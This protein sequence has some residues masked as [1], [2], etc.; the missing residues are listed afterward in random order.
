MR[1]TLLLMATVAV[2]FTF[3]ACS[4]CGGTAG[5]CD[6]GWDF[7]DECDMIE[8]RDRMCAS[9]PCGAGPCGPAPCAPGVPS[10]SCS[11]CGTVAPANTAPC[12]T[13]IM[14]PPAAPAPEVVIEEAP[15][16]VIEE[17]TPMP[18][19]IVSGDMIPPANQPLDIDPLSTGR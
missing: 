1:T 9:D 19:P 18:A 4:N 11:P 2:A 13:P 12:G 16:A 6:V 7:Y 8:G 14:L 17:G 10:T 3:T 5:N 15:A